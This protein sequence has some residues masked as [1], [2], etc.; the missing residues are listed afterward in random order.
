MYQGMIKKMNG[1]ECMN[2]KKLQKKLGMGILAAVMVMTNAAAGGAF[3]A[4]AEEEILTL[5]DGGEL[6]EDLIS[7]AAE[8]ADAAENVDGAETI[9]GAEAADEADALFETEYVDA[10]DF[11][12]EA[13]ESLITEGALTASESLAAEGSLTAGDSLIEEETEAD[14]L[15]DSEKEGGYETEMISGEVSEADSEEAGEEEMTAGAEMENLLTAESASQT[16]GGED[17]IDVSEAG[18]EGLCL[19]ET[20]A[21][22]AEAADALFSDDDD[23]DEDEPTFCYATK[24]DGTIEITGYTGTA[25]LLCIPETYDRKT[26]TSI[27]DHAFDSCRTLTSI[28]LPETLISIGDCAF[29]GCSS[30]QRI[31]LPENVASIGV[32]AFGFCTSL[33]SITL[34]ASITSIGNYAFDNCSGLVNI[35]LNASVTGIGDGTFTGCKSLKAITLPSSVKSIGNSAFYHCDS[36]IQVVMPSVTSIGEYAFNSCSSLT[37]MTL[38]ASVT[39]I[40]KGAYFFCTYLTSIT[41]PSSVTSVGEEVWYGCDQLSA[42]N[43][44]PENP[45][46]KSVDGVLM[47]KDGTVLI[48]Y[49]GGKDGTYQVPSSVTRIE[50]AAFIDCRKLTGITLPSSVTEIG[51]N[52]FKFCNSLSNVYFTGTQEQ[53]NA[54]SIENDNDPLTHATLHLVV[55]D[56]AVAATCT[57]AGHTAVTDKAVE[58]TCTVAGKTEGS[59]CSLCGEV[60]TAQRAIKALG[61]SY[62]T[63]TTKATTE[64]DGS[65]VS[66]CTV[67][68]DVKSGRVISHPSSV[69][70]SNAS[71]TYNKKAQ[72]PAVTVYDAAGKG[73]AADSYTLSWS[74]ACV[75]AGSY[76]VTVTFKGNYTGTLQQSFSIKKAAQKVTCAVSKKTFK[77][78][79][80]KKG[81]KTFTIGAK[82]SG[83]G[84]VTYQSSGKWVKVTKNGRVTVKKGAKK[85]TYKITVT[86]AADGNYK[87]ASKVIKIVVK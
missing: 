54:V 37:T 43:V 85:G 82:A 32:E 27:G 16:E 59:H 62:K 76:T 4:C 3:P 41:L 61:H 29:Y 69:K 83:S 66:A 84:K 11:L 48:S 12:T 8:I 74:G 67:C 60:I 56:P 19:F 53:W 44:E 15:L 30:L 65:I 40:G 55:T 23:E 21:E 31:E 73:I 45:A 77:A 51:E 22:I 6:S 86:A 26:V 5:E 63:T 78:S 39:S 79:T 25:S 17:L 72:K 13:S 33:E 75:N 35:F 9:D 57:V 47:T 38:P 50:N 71:F 49:P 7:G 20:E 14:L 10:E 18:E 24:E 58:A 46:Y 64:K 34:P 1:G 80:L 70:L 81:K 2:Q 42:I 52:A 28:T 87:K 36:L 68:G